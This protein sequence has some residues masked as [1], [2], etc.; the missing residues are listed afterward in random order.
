MIRSS[1]ELL[2]AVAQKWFDVRVIS[3][4]IFGN[5]ILR[6]LAS[7]LPPKEPLTIFDIGANLGDTALEFSKLFKNANIRAFEPDPDTFS[8]LNERLGPNKRRII[9]YNFGFGNAAEWRKLTV[10]RGSGG[11]SFLDISPRIHEHASGS[12]TEPRGKVNAEIR[13]VNSFCSDNKIA[14]I[15]LIKID[16]QG[17][18][19]EILKGGNEIIIAGKTTVIY[20]EVLFVE[21]YEG[22]TFFHELYS[23]LVSRGFRLVGLYN[24][25]YNVK[26][27]F[28]LLWCDALFVSEKPQ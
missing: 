26:N 4:K 23:E 6:D 17:Y 20:I 14:K 21:L 7:I 2:K 19:M 12:W 11:N 15:D 9:T 27:P 10:N 1:K 16:T 22:Q 24:P 8:T 28:Y 25:I 3:R 5:D 18:E 13:T